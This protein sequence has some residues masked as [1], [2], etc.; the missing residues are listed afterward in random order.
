MNCEGARNT[1]QGLALVGMV[2]DLAQ[3]GRNAVRTAIG[4]E[5]RRLHSE[6]L[7]KEIPDRIAELIKQL[8]Q[9]ME[10]SPRGQDADDA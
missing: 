10:A 7:C 3:A 4:A 5:L 9:Q 1:A 2:R 6:L 8:D